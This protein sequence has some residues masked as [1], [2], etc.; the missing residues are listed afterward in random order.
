MWAVS[1][2]LF[3]S[4]VTA[5]PGRSTEELRHGDESL[6]VGIV[7]NVAASRNTD[8]LDRCVDAAVGG[9]EFLALADGMA[10]S[11]SPWTSCRGAAC[12]VG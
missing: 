3:T 7:E 8:E 12:G 11:A 2:A 9:G 1:P 4:P 10:G 6:A 5:K